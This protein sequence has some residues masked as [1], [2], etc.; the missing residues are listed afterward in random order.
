V[1]F[2][3]LFIYTANLV[4][5]VGLVVVG[6]QVLRLA[7]QIHAELQ[8][9]HGSSARDVLDRLEAAA[10][11]AAEV[12][13][14]AQIASDTLS[15]TMSIAAEIAVQNRAQLFNLEA[16]ADAAAST[17]TGVAVDLAAAHDRADQTTGE[18]GA[19]ADAASQSPR[20]S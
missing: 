20:T 8:P 7:H 10:D 4:E 6:R 1:S 13:S 9:N 2:I 18:P 15:T 16:K 19:A 3:R 12:A 5:I 17:A 14:K 11:A